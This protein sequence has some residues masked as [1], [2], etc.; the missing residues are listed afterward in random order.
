VSSLELAILGGVFLSTVFLVMILLSTG[1]SD[2]EKVRRRLDEL[3]KNRGN[4][5]LTTASM[6]LPD[7]ESLP[8]RK[9]KL[10][11]KEQFFEGLDRYVAGRSFAGTIRARLRKADLKLQVSEFVT[12]DWGLSL[13]LALLGQLAAGLWLAVILWAAGLW[14]P[15]YYLSYLAEKRVKQVAAQLPDALSIMANAMKSGYSLLQAME[16]V[17][18]EM[19]S[20]ISAE[21]ALVIKETRVN[22][23]VED[24]LFNLTQRVPSGD[25]DLMVTAMLIQRQI[26]GN[27]SEILEKIN[28][29]IR[30]RIRILGEVRTLTAQGRMSG[31]IV[32]GLPLALGVI[33]QVLSPGYVTPLF[34]NPIGW[35]LLG[36]AV[37]MQLVGIIFIRS[38]IHLEV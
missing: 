37:V 2:Q 35:A 1:E 38:I 7:D 21:F 9:K 12:I 16:V 11:W 4:Q 6:T 26:G 18:R 3:V 17:S 13:L 23:S 30:E 8:G 24:A 15:W 27:L 22:I 29:T 25:L 20:P 32:G 10:V 36:A 19:P 14:L 33:L 28:E 31:F 5:E 34:T